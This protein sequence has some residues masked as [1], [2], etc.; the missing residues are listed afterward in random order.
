LALVL[1]GLACIVGVL[2]ATALSR[3][4]LEYDAEHP[5]P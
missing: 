5:T 1:G 3:R 4:F 2:T